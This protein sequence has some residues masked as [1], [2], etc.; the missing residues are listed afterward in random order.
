MSQVETD[1][2]NRMLIRERYGH[3][4]DAVF[5]QNKS[6]WLDCY[7]EDGSWL[8]F[9]KQVTGKDQLSQQWDELWHSIDT[10][11]FFSELGAIVLD[12]DT[13]KVRSYCHEIVRLKSGDV[14]KVVAQYSDELTQSDN[15]W[16]FAVRDYQV[17]IRES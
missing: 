3:Y 12:G 15:A 1:L 7:R 4:S 13:A 10:M 6:A 16:R 2:L 14:F 11:A 17:L 8:V 9:G 5:Q